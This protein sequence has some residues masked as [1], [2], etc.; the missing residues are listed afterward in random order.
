MAGPLGEMFDHGCDAINTT[1]EVVLVGS[2]MNLGRSWWTVAALVFSLAT[3]YLTT[4][5]EYHTK[6]LYLGL[7]SGPVEGILMIVGVFLISGRYGSKFWHQDALLFL[8]I[9]EKSVASFS[10]RIPHLKLHEVFM[11]FSGAG[12]VSNIITSCLNVSREER[13]LKRSLS[14]ALFRLV[15][16]VLLALLHLLWLSAP[17]IKDSSIV[18]SPLILPFMLSWGLQFAHQVGRVILAH[19]TNQPFPFWDPFWIWLAAAAV[20][21]NSMRLLGCEPLFQKS[22]DDIR[23]VVYITLVASFLLYARFVALVINDITEYLGIACFTVRKKDESGHWA[24]ANEV[25]EKRK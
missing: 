17:S 13:A 23:I 21:I 20:D 8:G 14:A 16:F 2:A 9:D 3:F 4:W 19:V 25:D 24:K 1:L 5:E 22:L 6:R 11:A 7:I 18:Y 12:L 15:P 10:A